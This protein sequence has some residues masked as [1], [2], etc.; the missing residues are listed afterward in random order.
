[1][2]ELIK[3]MEKQARLSAKLAKD[4]KFLATKYP[5]SKE[6]ADYDRLTFKASDLRRRARDLAA[7]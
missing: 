7:K 5:D 1:M 6:R 3:A 2:K 4:L